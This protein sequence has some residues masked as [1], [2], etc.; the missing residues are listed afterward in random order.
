MA[1]RILLIALGGLMALLGLQALRVLLERRRS[2][3]LLGTAIDTQLSVLEQSR[4][5]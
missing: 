3:E 1:K 5:N 4:L 2:P